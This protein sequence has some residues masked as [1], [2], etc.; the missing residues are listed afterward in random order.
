MNDGKIQALLLDLGGVVLSNGWDRESRGRAAEAFD[1]DWDD[2]NE[3]HHL[4]ADLFDTG[5]LSLEE[6]L[7]RVIFYRPRPFSREAFRAFMFDRSKAHPDMINL[8][9]DLKAHYT[10]R[11]AALSNESLELARHRVETFHLHAF[12]D[13]F[14]ISAFVGL[15]KPDPAIYRLALDLLQ[16]PPERTAYLEDRELFVEVARDFGIDGIHH[17]G[18]ESTL[19]AFSERGLDLSETELTIMR[20]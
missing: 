20:T 11:I 13:F 6:Y 16:V 18:F 10:L 7:D 2:F 17:T 12:V 19:E 14:I 1:L 8:V 9:H 15:K 3:R 4:V 5:K